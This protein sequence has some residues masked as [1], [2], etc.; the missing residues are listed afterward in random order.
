MIRY[1]IFGLFVGSFIYAGYHFGI[2]QIVDFS[3]FLIS[4]RDSALSLGY[5][6]ALSL[7]SWPLFIIFLLRILIGFIVTYVIFIYFCRLHYRDFALNLKGPI[8]A[9][10]ASKRGI[11]HVSWAFYWRSVLLMVIYFAVSLMFIR[12]EWLISYFAYIMAG[13]LALFF[14]VMMLVLKL[15]I[16]KPISG[17]TLIVSEKEPPQA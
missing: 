12:P 4:V 10:L 14:V 13:F 5:V 15:I 7:F 6:E 3:S 11:F 9:P 16:N 8:S 1:L 2:S 17:F